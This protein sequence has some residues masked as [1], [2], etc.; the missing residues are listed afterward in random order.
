M[1]Q[2]RWEKH[3]YHEDGGE[4][5]AMVQ[6]RNI[7]ALKEIL[8]DNLGKNIVIGTHGTALSTSINYYNPEFGYDYFLRIIDRMPYIVEMDFD[9]QRLVSFVEHGHIEKEFKGSN[10][11]DKMSGDADA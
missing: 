9:G 8:A 3:D 2:K 7:E 4:S 5:I 10:R 6:R 11:I 1:Y